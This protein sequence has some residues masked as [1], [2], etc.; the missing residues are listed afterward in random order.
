VGEKITIMNKCDKVLVRVSHT[1][2]ISDL[3]VKVCQLV[4]WAGHMHKGQHKPPVVV[5]QA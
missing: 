5:G 1:W 4:E 3:E 2:L